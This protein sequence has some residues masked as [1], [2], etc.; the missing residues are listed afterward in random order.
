MKTPR[1]TLL[2]L[3]LASLAA[4]MLASCASPDTPQRRIAR[5]PQQF[6]T[7][8]ARDREMVTNG[9]IREGMT[10]EGVFLAWG[11]PAQTSVGRSGGREVEQWIYQSQ[12]PV[13]VMSTS[14]GF[15][16]GWGY[17]GCGPWGWGYPG[18]RYGWGG[19]MMGMGSDVIYMPYTSGVVTFR[20][21]RV[22]EWRAALR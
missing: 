13:R 12:R 9:M 18:G 17:G 3:V 2:R 15:G 20:S 22:T 10:R 6:M 5:N 7:L 21:G 11:L 16:G 4:V 1:T 8:S 19:P 14:I